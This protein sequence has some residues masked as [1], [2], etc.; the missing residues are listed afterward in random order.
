[1]IHADLC[2][3]MY[4]RAAEELGGRERWVEALPFAV[5]DYNQ[6]PV[7]CFGDLRI[8]PFEV[9]MFV[10]PFHIEF[11]RL[12]HRMSVFFFLVSGNFFLAR[13]QFHRRS[14]SPPCCCK[15]IFSSKL[16]IPF[17]DHLAATCYGSATD[18]ATVLKWVSSHPAVNFI[19][20]SFSSF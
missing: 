9:M 11:F 19:N 8:S 20:S 3:S 18:S 12:L 5:I 17:F 6:T 10:F 13:M 7:K 15:I 16:I 4:K 14:V 2:A 1:M